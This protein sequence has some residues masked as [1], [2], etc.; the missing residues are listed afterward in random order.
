VFFVRAQVHALPGGATAWRVAIAI[1]GLLIVVVGVILLPLPGPGWLIIFLGIGVWATEF[2]WARRLLSHT[3][4]LVG[5]WT[6]WVITQPRSRQVLM[7]ATGFAVVAVFV[8]L[9][10]L[11]FFR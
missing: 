5:R 10:W 7:G 3:R 8:A 4:A 2:A 9:S 11:W 6:S 1:V